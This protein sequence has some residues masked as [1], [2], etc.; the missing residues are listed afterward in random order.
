VAAKVYEA[1][2]ALG[3]GREIPTEWFVEDER[4]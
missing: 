3:I 2:K 4:N 1:A